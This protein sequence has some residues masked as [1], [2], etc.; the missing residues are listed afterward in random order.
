MR[1]LCAGESVLVLLGS[2][3]F[4]MPLQVGILQHTH[5][6]LIRHD[7]VIGHAP[8]TKLA[9][10]LGYPVIVL[11]PSL[12]DI[13][14]SLERISQIV[15]PKEIGYIL[16]KLSVGPG[17]RI[18]EAGTGS[19]ALTAA[20]AHAVRPTGR[21]YSYDQRDDMLRVATRNLT[22]AALIEWAELKQRDI[23][24]G[25]DERDADALFLD[26]REPWL[27]LQQAWSA[28]AEGGFFGSIVPTTNQVSDLIAG[29]GAA[30]FTDVEVCEI[31]LRSYK[32]VPARLRPVDRMVAHTGYLVFARRLEKPVVAVTEDV[33]AD[34]SMREEN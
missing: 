24:E 8:G 27:Y 18:V 10:H 29:L 30:H 31:L 6:G 16:I 13:I 4:L 15:Y 11:R 28:L 22:N 19:G 34:S 32:P 17:S 23:A 1:A 26:V 33:Q 2:K 14:M 5:H 7:D 12:Y 3:R 25:F 21:V 20:I 9:T